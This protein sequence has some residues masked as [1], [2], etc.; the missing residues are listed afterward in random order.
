MFNRLKLMVFFLETNSIL[1]R[2]DLCCKILAP[3]LV[4]QIMTYISKVAGVVFLAGWN[5]VSVFLEYYLLWKVFQSVSALSQKVFDARHKDE[6]EEGSSV[7]LSQEEP[8]GSRGSQESIENDDPGR[9]QNGT[10]ALVSSVNTRVRTVQRKPGIFK[11]FKKRI[12]TFKNGWNIYFRQPVSRPGL[13]LASLYF[14]VISF[15]AITTGYA[16]TQC[17]S[18]SILSIVRGVGS[19]F[20][21]LAT[22]VF[23]MLRNAFGIV[24][25]GLFS[26][27]LQFSCLL[28]CVAAV[29]AP[30]SPFFLLPQSLRV[31][32]VTHQCTATL[33]SSSLPQCGEADLPTPTVTPTS[34]RMVMTKQLVNTSMS[35][36]LPSSAHAIPSHH[37]VYVNSTVT[38]TS[39]LVKSSFAVFI[40]ASKTSSTSTTFPTGTRVLRHNSSTIPPTQSCSNATEAPTVS[41]KFSYVSVALLL[42]GIVTSRLGLWMS[43]LAITQLFQEAVPEQERGIVA[44][45]QSSFNS[46]LSLLMFGLVIAL[47][48]PEHFGLLTL[49]S[50]CA[51]GTGGLLYASFAYKIRGHLFHLEKLRVFCGGSTTDNQTASR[52]QDDLDLEDD[53]EEAMIRGAHSTRNENFKY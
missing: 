52:L 33:S 3:I 9:G 25:C 16:Y 48:K 43:D 40:N 8:Q 22:F 17:L 32:T 28:L 10:E 24:R 29:F 23:P 30:G 14:T 47:P 35:S 5:V 12:I 44:G 39:S 15:G 49:M 46:V 53:E 37:T 26:M 41:K 27:S 20:G 38:S 13:A 4:G 19:L 31:D 42:A 45:M 36:L 6:T 50:V 11:R 51:V 18:E 2:I 34:Q 7:D 21:V 1:R